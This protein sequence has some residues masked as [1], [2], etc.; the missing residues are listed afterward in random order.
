METNFNFN[1]QVCTSRTQS[2]KLLALGLKPETADMCRYKDSDGCWMTGLIEETEQEKIEYYEIFAWSFDRLRK[3]LPKVVWYNDVLERKYHP[4]VEYE[5]VNY[6]TEDGTYLFDE[7]NDVWESMIV[8]IE[9]LIKEGY[10]NKEY[11]K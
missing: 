1:S 6:V 9:W 10:F 7:G 4:I 5:S 2:E 3:M 11:L 8:V